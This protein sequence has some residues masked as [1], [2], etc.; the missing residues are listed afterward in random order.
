M[1]IRSC[2][3]ALALAGVCW[4]QSG[5]SAV[6]SQVLDKQ[7]A[8][9]QSVV[10]VNVRNL[11]V[12]NHVFE[13]TV[14]GGPAGCTL[15][16]QSSI[17]AVTWTTQS[18]Q[19]CTTMGN[20][21]LTGTYMYLTVNLTALSGGTSPNISVNYRGY[22]P[23]QG[24]PVR[25]AEGG[26]GTITSF[27]VGSVAYAVANGVYSQDNANFFWDAT[28]KRLCLLSNTC[29][30]TL[31]VGGAKFYVTAAGLLGSGEQTITATSAGVVPDTVTGAASQT[32]DL[33]Q[34]KNSGGTVI[35]STSAAGIRRGNRLDNNVVL[36]GVTKSDYTVTTVAATVTETS[37]NSY[38]IPANTLAANRAIR[39]T[40]TGT[41]STANG[42]DTVA[43]KPKVGG[44]AW[45]TITSTAAGVTNAQ[46]SL[47]WLIVART[48]GA[49]GDAESQLPLAFINS[50]FKADPATAVK[51]I[52]TTASKTVEITATWSA[53]TAGN[54]IS[55][56]Q[57]VVEVLN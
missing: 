57:F 3:L 16:I 46:W 53:N 40:A 15:L 27:T 54:T 25:P 37:L 51:T 10:F 30:N 29:T 26:T 19:T 49:S 47:S 55:I 8:T 43:L 52:D 42:T 34:R 7:S 23:G 31:D 39:V 41:Y 12:T 4:G 45:H 36:S 17:D 38:S 9:G 28:N 6:F 22:L 14:A 35:A 21:A 5:T 20:V 50:V 2:T 33:E 1:S 32:A 44:T 11:G 13:W 24:L 48:L 56:R 18:T